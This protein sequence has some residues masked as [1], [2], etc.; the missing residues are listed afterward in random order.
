MKAHILKVLVIDH[1]EMGAD[2]V[3]ATLE[4]Q[5]YPNGCIS[6]QVVESATIDIGE[7][8]DEHPL[9]QCDTDVGA[10]LAA[11]DGGPE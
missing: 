2:S 10:W 5:R 11:H 9:N 4:L 7:W 6:P 8:T 1:D 3:S